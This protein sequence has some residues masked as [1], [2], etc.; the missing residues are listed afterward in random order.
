M[1]G[2]SLHRRRSGVVVVSISELPVIAGYAICAWRVRRHAGDRVEPVVIES[3][4]H[5]VQGS[6]RTNVDSAHGVPHLALRVRD[7][8]CGYQP[9]TRGR[10]YRT[11]IA[12]DEWVHG[13]DTRART[14]R[15]TSEGSILSART[16]PRL[17]GGIPSHANCAAPRKRSPI[18]AMNGPTGA[19]GA[20]PG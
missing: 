10:R 19:I 16:D 14:P 13:G 15:R 5:F 4:N 9:G 3:G 6:E 11:V 20:R 17:A 18:A 12:R 8:A 7:P 1:W 2:N